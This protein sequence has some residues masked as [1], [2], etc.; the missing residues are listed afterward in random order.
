MLTS[1]RAGAQT[2]MATT[3]GGDAGYFC[4]HVCLCVK[5]ERR[6][7]F[8]KCIQ[9]NQRGTMTTEPLAVSY[10][11]GEDETTPNKFHFFE[12]YQ[13]R[14]GF[15]AHTKVDILKSQLPFS[16][17]PIS[18]VPISNVLYDLTFAE[19]RHSEKAGAFLEGTVFK[20]VV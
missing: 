1:R 12:A 19:G 11:F 6:N 5:P 16:N 18:D 9:A 15:E 10:L 8:L 4:L 14:A 20:R 13:G 17:V 2:K 3:P 7:E